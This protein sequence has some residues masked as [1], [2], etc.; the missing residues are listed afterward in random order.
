MP[1][2]TS[3]QIK[4]TRLAKISEI[5]TNKVCYKSVCICQQHK[6]YKITSLSAFEIYTLISLPVYYTLSMVFTVLEFL[7][8]Q[9]SNIQ[10][11]LCIVNLSFYPQWLHYKYKLKVLSSAKMTWVSAKYFCTLNHQHSSVQL[12]SAGKYRLITLI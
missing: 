9:E 12:F 6:V 5:Y 2:V 8:Q 4:K 3:S 1:R 10:L 7:F 11:L